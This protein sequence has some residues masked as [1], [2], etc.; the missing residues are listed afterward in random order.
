MIGHF[1]VNTMNQTQFTFASWQNPK[2]V[3]WLIKDQIFFFQMKAKV[4]S[5]LTD[6]AKV[7]E[8]FWNKFLFSH[9]SAA[10]PCNHNAGW[11]SVES[12]QSQMV[13][14]HPTASAFLSH[15]LCI[16]LAH[17][18]MRSSLRKCKISQNITIFIKETGNFLIF[19]LRSSCP[20]IPNPKCHERTIEQ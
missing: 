16:P 17:Q 13:L 12:L 10:A 19:L 8:C 3:P 5:V 4:V 2:F 20:F 1:P 14:S 15:T 6:Q 9:R 18:E 11:E 7:A